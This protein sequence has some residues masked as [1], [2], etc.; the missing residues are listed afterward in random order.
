M[1]ATKITIVMPTRERGDVLARALATVTA[2]DYDGLEIVVSDNCSTDGTREV[3]AAAGD[4]RIRYLNTGRRVSMTDNWEFALSHVQGDGWVTILGDD[5]GLMP[6]AVARVAR[7]IQT[8]PAAT[9]AIR[10]RVCKYSWPSLTGTPWGRLTVPLDRGHEV[11]AARPWLA[12]IMSGSHSYADLPILYNGG[13]I[14]TELLARIKAG[15]AVYRS[16]IPD[17]YSAVAICSLVDHFVFSHEPF[18]ISGSSKH[19]TGASH[20]VKDARAAESSPAKLFR[21][22]ESI[23]FHAALPREPDGGYPISVHALV[24]ESYL[25]T[26]FLRGEHPGAR[27]AEQLAV[28]LA[29]GGKNQ[30]TVEA[31]GQRFAEAHGLD[32]ARCRAAATRLGRLRRVQRIPARLRSAVDHLDLGS[33][34]LPIRDVFEATI[35]AAAVRATLP[36]PITRLSRAAARL[37]HRRGSAPP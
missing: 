2:Q 9:H 23:P 14:T 11:R 29:V 16:P 5:D 20:F 19:S 26:G 8:S 27:H 7:L 12:R 3:V 30:E 6:G 33:A 31:W 21:R 28:M 34:E 37:V 13:F 22:E 32:Y 1:T 4:P 17:I 36:G 24:Y 18:A 10:S 25:Q 15:G 35:A